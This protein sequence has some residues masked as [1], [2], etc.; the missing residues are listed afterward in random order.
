MREFSASVVAVPITLK[1]TAL[2]CEEG[3]YSIKLLPFVQFSHFLNVSTGLR[4]D[5]QLFRRA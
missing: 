2:D 4:N 3:L 1:Q 5:R